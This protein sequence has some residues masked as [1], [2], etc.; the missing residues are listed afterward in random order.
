MTFTV[1]AQAP[2]RAPAQ[3]VYALLADYRDGHPRVLPSAFTGLR[4]IEG[5][6]GAGTVIDVEMKAF[7]R[8]RTVRGHVTEPEPGRVLE[9]V[10]PEAGIVTRF[11]VTPV[12]ASQSKVRIWSQLNSKRGIA[13]WLERK[14]ITGYLRKV[15]KQELTKIDQQTATATN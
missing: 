5:G 14:L 15:Y 11:Y 12:S 7:G 4:V 2:V 6:T 8:V 9:E 1:E 10:Y 3:T 13:G